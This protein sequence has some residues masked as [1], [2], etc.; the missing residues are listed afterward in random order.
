MLDLPSPRK[1]V[2]DRSTTQTGGVLHLFH[3]DMMEH[4]PIFTV[5]LLHLRRFLAGTDISQNHTTPVMQCPDWSPLSSKVIEL[6][7]TRLHVCVR[8]PLLQRFWIANS[9]EGRKTW[10]H[11]LRCGMPHHEST[12]VSQDSCRCDS[13]TSYQ[14]FLLLPTTQG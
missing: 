2:A 7:G 4:V 1:P 12:G 6:A 14:L 3:R 8:D 13:G 5:K 9:A 11:H 10:I